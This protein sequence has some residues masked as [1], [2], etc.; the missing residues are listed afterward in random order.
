[1]AS[2]PP[3][4][5]LDTCRSVDRS[6]RCPGQG[7]WLASSGMLFSGSI[8]SWPGSAASGEAGTAG[9]EGSLIR[10]LYTLYTAGFL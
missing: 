7:C 6:F 10:W 4:G 1:M 8:R 5:M 3:F 2:V 9:A